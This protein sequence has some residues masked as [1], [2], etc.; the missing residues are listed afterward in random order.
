MGEAL[1]MA[2][3]MVTQQKE[4]Y[5]AYSTPY[6]RP[7]IFVI[8]DGEPNDDY[9]S[10]VQR[11]KQMEAEKRVLAYCVGVEKYNKELMATIFDN[12][13]LFQL[14]ELDFPSLFEFVSNS[15]AVARNSEPGTQTVGVTAANTIQMAIQ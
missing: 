7:W 1:N 5:N 13:R 14:A 12:K 6:Y 4:K 15:L 8:T 11:L 9:Q 10:A 2:M 3:D